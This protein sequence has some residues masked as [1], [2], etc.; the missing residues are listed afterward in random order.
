M[1]DDYLRAYIAYM[2]LQNPSLWADNDCVK[3][4]LYP[5]YFEARKRIPYIET[6]SNDELSFYLF[7]GVGGVCAL[8]LIIVAIMIYAKRKAIK[9]EDDDNEEDDEDT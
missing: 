4:I 1:S 2:E 7:M 6:F 9:G 5:D 3:K 8:I